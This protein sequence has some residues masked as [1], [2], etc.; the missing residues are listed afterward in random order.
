MPMTNGGSYNFTTQDG[1]VD[2]TYRQG[3]YHWD[4]AAY[5]FST[6]PSYIQLEV[7]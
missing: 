6:V 3:M 1:T 2:L 4:T 7:V 5:F